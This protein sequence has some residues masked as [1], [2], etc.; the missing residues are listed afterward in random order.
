MKVVHEGHRDKRMPQNIASL[1]SSCTPTAEVE[2][3]V[4][5]SLAEMQVAEAVVEA[6]KT[7]NEEKHAICIWVRDLCCSCVCQGV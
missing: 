6:E 7:N 1:L 3:E 4:T 5:A 2:T